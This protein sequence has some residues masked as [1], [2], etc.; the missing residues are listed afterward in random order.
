M[1]RED[2]IKAAREALAEA[3]PDRVADL[4][5]DV[6]ETGEMSAAHET[7]AEKALVAAI[8]AVFTAQLGERAT[9]VIES[10]GKKRTMNSIYQVFL[11]GT[12]STTDRVDGKG[13]CA[14]RLGIACPSCGQKN[15]VDYIGSEV[16][17]GSLEYVHLVHTEVEDWFTC[18]LCGHSFSE[19]HHI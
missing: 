8:E 2:V 18:S 11:F 13:A 3:A 7:A 9:A 19:Y 4:S 17:E 16:E 15:C 12:M 6:P 1:T 10:F 5:L 14:K